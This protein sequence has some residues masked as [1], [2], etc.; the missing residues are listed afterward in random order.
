MRVS[1]SRL[2]YQLNNNYFGVNKEQNSFGAATPRKLIDKIRKSKQLKKL[3]ITFDEL[4]N[5]YKEIGYDV[6]MKRGSHAVIPLGNG[7][8]IPLPIP[9]KAKGVTAYDLKRFRFILEGEIER[10]LKV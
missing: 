3:N 1:A 10:A 2:N 4:V 5:A 6:L 7:I 9:H 8:N